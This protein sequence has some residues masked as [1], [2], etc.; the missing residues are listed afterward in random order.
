[1]SECPFCEILAGR[2]PAKFL[3]DGISSIAIEPLNPV[4]PGHFIVIPRRHV[5]DAYDDT[6]VTAMTM[7]DASQWAKMFS[8][9]DKRYESVNFITSVGK[10]ATQSVF[11]LHIHVVPRTENDGL[12]LPWFS[13]KSRKSH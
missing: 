1:M 13:G 12:A 4:T 10:P 2:G 6:S 5:A 8:W 11:H 3:A 7:H 9:R